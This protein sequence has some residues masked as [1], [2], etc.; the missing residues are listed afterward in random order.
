MSVALGVGNT[1][2][3][4]IAELFSV[5]AGSLTRHISQLDHPL[6]RIA[7]YL[8]IEPKRLLIIEQGLVA[9]TPPLLDKGSQLV[10]LTAK[11]GEGTRQPIGFHHCF[12][13]PVQGKQCPCF[14]L[15]RVDTGGVEFDGMDVVLER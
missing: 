14:S 6:L 5:V 1:G 2:S 4:T 8:P 3:Y 12:V 10:S 7:Q 13:Q 15:S 11:R 9:V